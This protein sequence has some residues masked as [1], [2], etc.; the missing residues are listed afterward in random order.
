MDS[1]T[2]INLAAGINAAYTSTNIARI[3]VGKLLNKARAEFKSDKLFGQWCAE[4]IHAD[5]TQQDRNEMMAVAKYVGTNS[6]EPEVISNLGWSGL[7][8]I[9]RMMNGDIG[10][11]ARRAGTEAINEAAFNGKL[12][13]AEAVQVA[14]KAMPEHAKAYAPVEKAL[15]AA[16]PAR[17]SVA[18]DKPVTDKPVTPTAVTASEVMEAS[19]MIEV[20]I[21][22]YGIKLQVEKTA[23]GGYEMDL[24]KS[25]RDKVIEDFTNSPQFEALKAKLIQSA[26][27]MAQKAAKPAKPVA[28][29]RADD[30]MANLQNALGSMLAG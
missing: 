10:E 8:S 12:T 23:S 1:N 3:E 21:R 4:N 9:S 27:S 19:T 7:V 20:A 14:A 15:Q 22:G 30:P 26:I 18:V 2:L 17:L 16:T 25:V 29:K 6:V 5:L 13:A 28:R 24:P 11:E